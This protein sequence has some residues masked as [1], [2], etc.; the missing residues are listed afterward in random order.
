MVAAVISAMARINPP[1]Y[2]FAPRVELL[3]SFSTVSISNGPRPDFLDV[4]DI[5]IDRLRR[6]EPFVAE[7]SVDQS[8]LQMA[9]GAVALHTARDPGVAGTSIPVQRLLD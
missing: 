6:D 3:N 9:L 7:T 1:E 2:C 8:V 4:G 5:L